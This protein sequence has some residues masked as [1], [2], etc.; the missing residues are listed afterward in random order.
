M[1]VQKINK[2]A[3]DKIV[4]GK[5]K[6]PATCII[7]FYSNGCDMCHNLQP[8]Y[9][10]IADEDQYDDLHFFAFN[11]DDYPPI[12][13]MLG[14]NG[15]PTIFLLKVGIPRRRMRMLTDPEEPHKATWYSSKYIKEFID[16]ER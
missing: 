14:F 5:V 3:L 1:P 6:E 8:Y 16:R 4:A 15:V 13:K 2:Q 10:A 7:K 11:V 12:E 9:Q